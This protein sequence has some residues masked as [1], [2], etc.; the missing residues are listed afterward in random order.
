MIKELLYLAKELVL[1]FGSLFCI[2]YLEAII[3][4]SIL[5]P[6]DPALGYSFAII[7]VT[8]LLLYFALKPNRVL[9]TLKKIEV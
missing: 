2:F 6:A 9:Q 7:N 5:A 1:W 3:L 4:R 8:P